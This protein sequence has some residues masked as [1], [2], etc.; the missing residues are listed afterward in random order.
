MEMDVRM[1]WIWIAPGL[2]FVLL[3]AHF[4]RAGHPHLTLACGVLLVVMTLRRG[5]ALRLAQVGLALGMLEW[6]WT[7]LRFVAQRQA[8]GQPWL[9]LALILGM[10]A[11][12]TGLS[13]ALLSHPRL[14]ARA[15]AGGRTGSPIDGTSAAVTAGREIPN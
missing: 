15:R 3:G 10:V 13:A 8:L 2:S 1:E 14:R 6:A 11:L 4:W 5:W 9:R 12:V 7:G